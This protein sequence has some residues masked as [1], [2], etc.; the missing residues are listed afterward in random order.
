MIY[1]RSKYVAQVFVHG[2]SL[3]TN[4]VAVV[5]PDPEVLPGAM[6]ALGI[7]SKDMKQLCND[8][9][10]KKLIMDDILALGKRAG[11]FSFEQV[12]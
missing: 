4:L 12:F 7:K 2:E 1:I 6:A 3:K 10:V 11:L 8:E 9:R 5:V